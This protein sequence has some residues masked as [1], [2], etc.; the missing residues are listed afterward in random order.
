MG[1][2]GIGRIVIMAILLDASDEVT[3]GCV[4]EEKVHCHGEQLFSIEEACLL[5]GER[6]GGVVYWGRA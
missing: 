1:M 2:G 4:L 5:R 3:G 6:S